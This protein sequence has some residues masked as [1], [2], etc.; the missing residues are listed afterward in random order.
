MINKLT[1]ISISTTVLLLYPA[2]ANALDTVPTLSQDT[3]KINTGIT[4]QNGAYRLGP[5]DVLTVHVVNEPDYSQ[6]NV[7]VRP[8]GNITLTGVGEVNVKDD[9][10][11]VARHKI[12]EALNKILVEPVVTVSV[13]TTRPAKIYL[14][15]AVQNPGS[16]EF[17][18]NAQD[19]NMH[20][21]SENPQVRTGLN[22]TNILSNAG[23]VSFDADLDHVQVKH[24]DTD[25]TE[26]ISLLRLLKE[27]AADQD[28]IL[29]S[30]D[31]VYVPKKLSGMMDDQEQALLLKS[32]FGP[33][34]IPVRILGKVKNPG[35]YELNGRSPYLNTVVAMAGGFMD[36][37]NQHKV[38]IRRFSDENHFSTMF[39][40]PDKFDV[41]LRP[42]DVIF[43]AENQAEKAGRFMVLATKMLSPFQS[44]AT[45]AGYG[46]QAFGYG[47][48]KNRNSSSSS[49]SSK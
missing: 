12:F 41:S 1:L 44:A 49:S 17:S 16:F 32:S 25:T 34:T 3:T 47:G 4:Y 45:I 27:G 21:Q 46:S 14:T 7:L 43:I 40:S 20:V 5:D 18:T 29:H 48:W 15:G 28:V 13:T 23:G 39:L 36:E 8:D 26:T 38:A 42:N 6:T 30:G 35:V 33:K 31:S 24:N 9:T 19:P 22:L 11:E 37:A 2:C 10:V